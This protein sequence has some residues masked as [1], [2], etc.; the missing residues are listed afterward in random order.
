MPTAGRVTDGR[1]ATDG[2]RRYV[3]SMAEDSPEDPL[4]KQPSC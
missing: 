2:D 4:L 3:R 1:P